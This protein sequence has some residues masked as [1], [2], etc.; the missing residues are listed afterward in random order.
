MKKV[1]IDVDTGIDDAIGILLAEKSGMADILGITTV[2]GNTSLDQATRN[3]R[4]ITKL[5]GRDDLKVV[6]GAARPLLRDPYFE[7]SVHGNDGIGGALRDMEVEI[8]DEGFAPDFIIE[9]AKQHPG[10][11][12]VILLAPLTNMALAIRKEPRL[13]EWLKELVIMGGAFDHRGNITPTAEYNMYIDPEAAKIVVHSGIPITMV[14]L[15]VTSQTLLTKAD[16]EAI[17]P[18]AARDFIEE[19]TVHY[20]NHYFS[21]NGKQACAMHDPLAVG[22]ALDRSLVETK[23]YYV[24]I[25]T[26]SD[27]CDGQTVC[28]FTNWHK[29]EPNVDVCVGVDRE[30]F[31]RMLVDTLGK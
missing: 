9:Q 5:L 8:R 7:V 24:D 14:G 3:T 30:R 25:E 2:N 19:A 28:D 4:K 16:V 15:D 1:I 10:E 23:K 11:I 6:Q 20:M 22:A 12:T 26:N 21:R 13:K 17:R 31:I 29:K 27:L 18:G